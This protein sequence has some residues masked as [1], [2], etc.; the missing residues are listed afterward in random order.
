VLAV[1]CG[2]WRSAGPE[3]E[4]AE[5]IFRGQCH[6]VIWELTNACLFR[7]A[8]AYNLG[9]LKKLAAEVPARL[10]ESEARGDLYGTTH[11]R[12]APFHI[13]W[14]ASDRPDL[15]QKNA[16]TAISEW[17][18]NGYLT[19]HYYHLIASTTTELYRGQPA[20]AAR[21]L[22][23]AMPA[24]RKSLLLRVQLVRMDTLFLRARIAVAQVTAAGRDVASR[25]ARQML[26]E[27][28][29][30]AAAWSRL[31]LA[32]ISAQEGRTDVAIEQLDR[33]AVELEDCGIQ[34]FAAAARYR[35]GVLLGGEAGTADRQRAERW[36][37]EQGILAPERMVQVLAPGF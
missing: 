4:R 6:G 20:E 33:A 16:D 17:S 21:I 27:K 26:A 18:A 10:L 37:N 12:L 8:S 11:L 7:L 35:R 3:L 9:D 23:E 15:A 2:Q 13:L 5:T 28:V 24:L 30:Y 29:P 32:A 31:V 25:C 1:Q 36:M 19:Q 22:A 14:L 34:L